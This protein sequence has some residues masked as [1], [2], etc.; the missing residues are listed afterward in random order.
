MYHLLSKLTSTRPAPENPRRIVLIRP[1]CIG[2]VI[3][4]TATLKALRRAYPDAHITWAMGQW[5][6]KV[7][8]HHT[9]F[10]DVLD[11]GTEAMPV[12]SPEGF[13]RFVRQLRAGNFDL[14]VSLVRS[15][16]MSAAL[17]VSGIPHRAGLDSAGRGFGYTVRALIDPQQ[18]RHEAEIFLDV[19]RAL[20]IDTA[21]CYAN[22][23]VREVDM[24]TVRD[25]LAAHGVGERFIVI[26]PAG[27]QNP[28]MTADS[29]RWS[30]ANFAALAD[31]LA[32][33]FGVQIVLLAGPDD[34]AIVQAVESEMSVPATAFVGELS[35]G[36]IPAL[37]S[38]ALVYIGNDTGI[39]HIA[40]AGGAKTVT[41]FGPTD[42]VRYAPFSPD[43]I[44]LWKPVELSD[45]AS[46]GVYADWDWV[47]D[48]IGLDE[49]EERIAAFVVE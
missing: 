48:G 26:N 1:C 17:L 16:L 21:D 18:P 19:A 22:L 30:P 35:F 44:T 15:P 31:R 8:E 29:K 11:T 10:D 39:T 42:P 4:A 24:E 14:A 49:A 41:I 13:W 36:E 12:S 45:W 28:G 23:P 2:D 32:A 46:G 37:A 5:S 3:Q 34:S 9:M 40:A 27:G 43:S 7:V 6:R 25:K 33:R 38:L 20:G 47:R